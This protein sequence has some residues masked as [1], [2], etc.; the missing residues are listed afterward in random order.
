MVLERVLFYQHGGTT[1]QVLAKASEQDGD[2]EWVE[3]SGGGTIINSSNV[4][5]ATATLSEDLIFSMSE[6]WT[7]YKISF[8]SIDND[9]VL[10]DGAVKIGK[11]ISKIL[12]STNLNFTEALSG[13]NLLL[14]KKNDDVVGKTILKQQ[15]ED[16]FSIAITSQAIDVQEGDVISLCMQTSVA[17]ENKTIRKN[18]AYMTIVAI[19]EKSE[20]STSDIIVS[21]TEPTVDRRKVWFQRSKNLLHNNLENYSGT[22]TS[23]TTINP[24]PARLSTM[25]LIKVKS[26]TSYTLSTTN[27]DIVALIIAYDEKGNYLRNTV[28]DWPNVSNYTFT[29]DSDCAYIRILFAF[30]DKTTNITKADLGQ[31][32]LEQGNNKTDYEP[33]IENAVYGKNDNGVYENF[34]EEKVDRYSLEETKTDKVWI[35]NRPIYRKV[36][37]FITDA[38]TYIMKTVNIGVENIDLCFIGPMSVIISS[39]ETDKSMYMVNTT[40]QANSTA[41]GLGGHNWFRINPNRKQVGYVVSDLT[42]S[43]QCYLELYYTKTTD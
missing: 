2:V 4:D 10:Q 39:T 38:E 15:T 19:Y 37:S 24:N 9:F 41:L 11:G 26:N 1:G 28:N 23:V 21:P 42:K 16:F 17:Q 31:C 3:Q 32:Q 13:V 34:T 7:D 6:T 22:S 40:R 20:V 14:I 36:L 43:S 5:V 29:T 33:F 35:D 25:K 18:S 8:D 30:T 27:T 12:I